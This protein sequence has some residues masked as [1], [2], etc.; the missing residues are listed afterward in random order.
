[1]SNRKILGAVFSVLV[2]VA[3]A[4]VFYHLHGPSHDH[5][6]DGA[7]GQMQL[8]A[9][10]KWETDAPLR[11]GM[12]RISVLVANAAPDDAASMQ[13]LAGGIREQVDYLIQ[14]C[15]LA[16]EADATLHVLLADLLQ[17]ADLVSRESDSVRG[18]S[19]INAALDAYPRYFTH[20]GWEGRAQPQE[21]HSP[22][23]Q[24]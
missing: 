12:E 22:G 15:K 18:L 19:V 13:N 4:A 7:H 1:M 16:P 9:G 14:N 24:P 3:G 23:A 10:Q 5:Q 2:L 6:H 17:G 8:N 20:A 21:Q 11:T